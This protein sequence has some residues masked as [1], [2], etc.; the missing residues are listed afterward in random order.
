MRL[1]PTSW[2]IP[3]PIQQI[4]PPLAI[5]LSVLAS[6]L[7]PRQA[8]VNS[9]QSLALYSAGHAE[10]SQGPGAR[11]PVALSGTLN[12]A[13]LSLDSQHRFWLPSLM[14]Q[15]LHPD[16]ERLPQL[17]HPSSGQMQPSLLGSPC[18]AL[19]KVLWSLGLLGTGHPHRDLAHPDSVWPG[20]LP[21]GPAGV[22][23]LSLECGHLGL[24][25]G[26]RRLSCRWGHWGWGGPGTEGG[27]GS[28][29]C[30]L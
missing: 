21:Q 29:G 4:I 3:V 16:P 25:R 18:W 26:P 1:A 7:V 6:H 8:S 10:T 23:H 17:L 11:D 13:G 27:L 2:P 30:G 19:R 5:A 28:G 15:A 9:T 24:V 14:S 22:P 20:A 12:R